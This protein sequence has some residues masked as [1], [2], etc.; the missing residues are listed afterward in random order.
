[1][2]RSNLE[3]VALDDESV[4]SRGRSAAATGAGV[5]TVTSGATSVPFVLVAERGWMA[6]AM[7]GGHRRADSG[8]VAGQLKGRVVLGLLAVVLLAGVELAGVLMLPSN[9]ADEA[10]MVESGWV[11]RADVDL[12]PFR[13]PQ[14]GY[15]LAVPERWVSMS[16]DGDI[17]EIGERTFHDHPELAEEFQELANA[18]PA[19]LRFMSVDPEETTPS[20][21]GSRV[22]VIRNPARGSTDP[23]VLLT[24]ARRAVRAIDGDITGDR[25]FMTAAG[26]AVRVTYDLEDSFSGIQYLIVVGEEVWTLTYTSR[27]IPEEVPVADAVAA[28]FAPGLPGG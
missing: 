17:S 2:A 12:V 15:E 21:L 4:V 11:E 8:A 28:T 1:M 27:E 22:T 6:S 5:P 20:E 25:T 18:R 16:F 23:G 24:Q 10:R 14:G 9:G 13:D 26:E 7:E 19:S 3:A